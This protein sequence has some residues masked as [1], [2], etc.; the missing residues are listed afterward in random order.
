MGFSTFVDLEE[1][2][3]QMKQANEEQKRQ[4]DALEAQKIDLKLDFDT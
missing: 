2:L 4:I 3:R 1:N